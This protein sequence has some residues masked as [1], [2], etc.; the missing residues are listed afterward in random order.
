MR[1]TKRSISIAF[2]IL[3]VSLLLPAVI[4]CGDNSK[5]DGNNIADE[6]IN[7]QPEDKTEQTSDNPRAN[8]PD[9]LPGDLDFGGETLRILMRDEER[10]RDEI[11]VENE[12]GE[13]VNDAIFRRNLTVEE[14][15]NMKFDYVFCPQANF[16]KTIQNSVG[17]GGDDYDLIAGFAYYIPPLSLEGIF[18]NW[19]NMP[20]ITLSQPWWGADCV[21]ELNI[22][23]K[24]YFVTGDLSLDW[25]QS[26][27]VYYFNKKMAQ[28]YSVLNLYELVLEGKWTFSKFAEIAK[29]IRED[30][31]GDGVYDQNDRYGYVAWEFANVDGYF[32]AFDQ[33]ITAPGSGGLPEFIVNTPRTAN[34]ID[35]VRDIMYNSGMIYYNSSDKD[36]VVPHM[37]I[38]GRN[39]FYYSELYDSGTIFKSMESD[40]GILPCPKYDEAQKEYR[41]VAHDVYSLFCVPVTCTRRE[42]TGAA[43]EAMA[44]ESYRKVTPMY[45]ETALKVKYTRDEESSQMLDIILQGAT[46][47]FGVVYSGAV[48]DVG[49]IMRD[50]LL[51]GSKNIS[52]SAYWEKNENRFQKALD[53]VLD[54]FSALSA[55][56]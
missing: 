21:K 11:F 6:E 29:S 12:I 42:L 32:A 40:F 14:R 41:T 30:L 38:E 18:L 47:N 4:S 9:L 7:L 13:I 5:N 48:S 44:A 1:F 50:L 22:G 27:Y 52:F 56:G 24:L 53:K 51:F 33:P 15:L 26:M 36:T 16:N 20:H 35:M 55:E 8:T 45:F 39:L 49:Y 46:F 3:T 43:T 54:K 25:I 28:Q 19:N 34:I 17:A 37:F 31:N 2:A 10:Y 23:G